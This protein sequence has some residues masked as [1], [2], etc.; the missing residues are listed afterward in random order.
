MRKPDLFFRCAV[1]VMAAI[2]AIACGKENHVDA[3]IIKDCTG[4]YLRIVNKDY[5]VCNSELTK[6]FADGQIVK[7]VF[8][9]ESEC[10]NDT[11]SPC[12]MSHN[13]VSY[14]QIKKIK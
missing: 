7:A 12:Y 13:F 11:P 2:F 9:L 3:I 4:T 10:N 14:A 1:A 5:K 8:T 6:G